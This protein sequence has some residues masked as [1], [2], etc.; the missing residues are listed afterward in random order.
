MIAVGR[1][2]LLLFRGLARSRRR[3]HEGGDA[4][5]T[6]DDH[7][8]RLPICAIASIIDAMASINAVR[9]SAFV[10]AWPRIFGVV[11]RWGL[12]GS[13]FITSSSAPTCTSTPVTG[14]RD[15]AIHS[16]NTR[17]ATALSAR[18]RLVSA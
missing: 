16:V 6:D 14:F 15:V 3:S 11:E 1:H 10:G 5:Y 13:R 9:A 2:S 17:D 7:G 18:L 4:R 8:L 12:V